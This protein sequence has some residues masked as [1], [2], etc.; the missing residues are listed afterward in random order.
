MDPVAAIGTDRDEKMIQV[1]KPLSLLPLSELFPL[2]FNCKFDAQF[3]NELSV[4]DCLR[5]DYK[6]F[7]SP[8]WNIGISSIMAPISSPQF[9]QKD[10][11]EAE[12]KEY[13]H[14]N[15]LDIL[16]ILSFTPLPSSRRELMMISESEKGT[17]LIN[18]LTRNGNLFLEL[19]RF[20]DEPQITSAENQ[21][22]SS[23]LRCQIFDQGNV[24]ASRKIL[25]PEINRFQLL[26]RDEET[27]S[28]L[29]R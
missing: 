5:F 11:L 27:E 25:S 9:L 23:G 6:L 17:E 22:L 28:R 1:L 14:S 29:G 7:D 2:L 8:Q 13:L 12:C 4:S 16:L 21:F 26:K 24:K 10:H 15:Q 19:N 20:E 18:Y 3:W